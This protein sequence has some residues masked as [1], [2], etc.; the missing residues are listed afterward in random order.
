MENASN[1]WLTRTG[2]TDRSL[3]CAAHAEGMPAHFEIR[4]IRRDI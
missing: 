4:K 2:Q 3:R 1:E